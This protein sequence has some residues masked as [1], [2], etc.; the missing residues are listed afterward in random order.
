MPAAS[1][2]PVPLPPENKIDEMPHIRLHQLACIVARVTRL[3]HRRFC[4]ERCLIERVARTSGRDLHSPLLTK[5]GGRI[6]RHVDIF[7]IKDSGTRTG[8]RT[9]GA[10]TRSPTNCAREGTVYTPGRAT[11]STHCRCTFFYACASVVLSLHS[12]PRT[13]PTSALCWP[14]PAQSSS[15][16]HDI[17][18]AE[19]L[20]TS[21]LPCTEKLREARRN[22]A[23]SMCE[24]A[25]P[26]RQSSPGGP[27]SVAGAGV[28]CPISRE[29]KSPAA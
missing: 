20:D 14:G 16:R 10:T 3:E 17:V 13:G 9:S 27:A 1:S 2:W 6:H 26:G 11:F 21:I 4:A 8:V 19:R 15:L 22:T 5:H 18:S 28:P 25:L 29:D 23:K 12:T 24:T 7:H